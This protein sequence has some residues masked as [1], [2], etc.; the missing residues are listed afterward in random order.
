MNEP[1]ITDWKIE[2]LTD[3]VLAFVHPTGPWGVNNAG[4]ICDGNRAS[5]L[6]DTLFTGSL[7]ERMLT[8]M[9]SVAEAAKNIEIVFNTH[10]N[11]DH[12]W[13]NGLIPNAEIIASKTGAAEM[14]KVTPSIMRKM[15]GLAKFG[16]AVGKV[17]GPLGKLLCSMGADIPGS[18]VRAAPFIKD[19]FGAFDFKTASFKP[20]TKTFCNETTVSIGRKEVI[21]KEFGP[22]HTEGD[23]IVF[24]P[25]DSVLFAGDLLFVGGHPLLWEGP[26]SNWIN[27]LDYMLSLNA[28]HIVP[29]HGPLTDRDG[30]LHLKS[31]FLT[32][33]EQ[34]Q[35]LFDA[36][37]PV[38]EAARR[39]KLGPFR[40]LN[41][42]E[43]LIVNVD[44]LYREF[45]HERPRASAVPCFA[46]M[47]DFKKQIP[48]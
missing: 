33:A 18:I 4:L 45:G 19:I 25:E 6:V 29:G 8:E 17:R 28:K 38:F 20:P 2:R 34:S 12:C 44:T 31:Y 1:S 39:I 10:A 21:L 7:T 16:N 3:D 37:V 41:E 48:R 36:G 11:G 26:V 22:S 42:G 15:M 24:I 47:A 46:M 27:A 5:L 30:I 23:S 40:A 43:R 9:R 13:G 14:Q 35:A 32:V